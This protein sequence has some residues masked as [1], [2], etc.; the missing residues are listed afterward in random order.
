MPEMRVTLK[1][2]AKAAGVSAM[3]VSKALNNK[4]GLSIETQKH[5]REVA[6]QLNY[7]PNLVAKS[8]R[9][10]ETKTLG[11]VVS[12]SSEMVTAKI[13]RGIQ[14]SALS[15]GYGV[16][17]NNTDG[18]KAQERRAVEILLSKCMDGILMVAPT[19]NTREDNEW[20]Y[21]LRTPIV[22]LMRESLH[23]SIDSVINNNKRG[24][25]DAMSCLLRSGRRKIRV[26]SLT[27]TSQISASRL[28]GCK[29][30]LQEYGLSLPSGSIRS[31]RSHIQDA[32]T[33]M[34]NW[35]D[36]EGAD[37]DGLFCGCDVIA[38]GAMNALY[39]RKIRIPKDVCV[40][41]Y[42]DIELARHLRVPLTTIRQPLYEIG[43]KGVRVLLERMLSPDMPAQS[44]I[45]D[46]LLIER[47]STDR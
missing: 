27:E 23:A 30:A 34:H 17:I 12:D 43:R 29:L 6:R 4:P 31:C 8:L 19:L 37:F 46:S 3:S 26:I 36:E 47:E 32:E 21:S 28:D 24:G 9:L 41:G 22:L 25:Y 33:V 5:I 44:V 7:R 45:L 1:D 40:C 11:V 42:D 39:E 15:E 2:V 18:E 20:L 10:D 13:L 14:D 38:I 35:I 16:L